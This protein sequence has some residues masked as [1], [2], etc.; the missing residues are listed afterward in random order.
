[1]DILSGE[2]LIDQF[3]LFPNWLAAPVN[4]LEHHLHHG[5]L[6][7]GEHLHFSNGFLVDLGTVVDLRRLETVDYPVS[8]LVPPFLKMPLN[9]L[10]IE[11]LKLIWL[12]LESLVKILE[13]LYIILDGLGALL[14]DGRRSLKSKC[15]PTE[16]LSIESHW[17]LLFS[18]T[19]IF[20]L[21]DERSELLKSEDSFGILHTGIHLSLGF[22][23]I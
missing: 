16:G 17:A 9:L 4:L 8:V 10:W 7:L 13:V 5:G 3:F 15:L 1:M 23:Q 14:L 6:A 12:N 20:R 21:R 2:V 11:R 22:D 18:H 19:D